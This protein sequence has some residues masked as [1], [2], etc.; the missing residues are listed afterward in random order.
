[1]SARSCSWRVLMASWMGARA[2]SRLRLPLARAGVGVQFRQSRCDRFLALLKLLVVPA[3]EVHPS[4]LDHLLTSLLAFKPGLDGCDGLG[5]GG[6]HGA[7]VGG[8]RQ[9][10]HGPSRGRARLCGPRRIFT[11]R[12]ARAGREVFDG[13]VDGSLRFLAPAPW[14]ECLFGGSVHKRL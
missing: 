11:P 3:G 2:A 4:V 7:G 5:D 8:L 14:C 9:P 12:R 1:A 10:R 13:S 6:L